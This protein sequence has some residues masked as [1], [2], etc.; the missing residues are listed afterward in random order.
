V[1]EN[2]LKTSF[3]PSWPNKEMTTAQGKIEEIKLDEIEIGQSQVRTDLTTGIDELAVSISKQG[4]LQAIVVTKLPNGNY[5]VLAGQR[6]FLACRKLGHQTIRANVLDIA[7]D[8]EL[9][10]AIS[11]TE[12]LVRL[13]NTQKEKIDACTKLYKKYAS[14]KDVAAETGLSVNLVSKYVK[15]DQ[16]IPELKEMVDNSQLDMKVALQAQAA[17]SEEDGDVDVEAATKFALEL[18]SMGD[19]QQKN[20][21]KAVIEDPTATLEEKIEKG[22]KQP[23]LKQLIVTLEASMHA[24]L[25]KYAKDEG[26]NQ[27]AAAS[28]LLE[29]GLVR[30]GFLKD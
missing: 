1:L 29:D 12:N 28:G 7:D 14:I 10:V 8:E 22:R 24:G 5:E 21:V 13:G 27:D 11:L 17:A 30:R 23:I 6:R 3:K 16:L 4:L 25:Q 26:V 2:E 18:N 9:K 20:F 19:A 15:Y